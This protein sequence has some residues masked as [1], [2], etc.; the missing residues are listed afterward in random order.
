MPVCVSDTVSAVIWP[1]SSLVCC[2]LFKGR[3]KEHPDNINICLR[4][5]VVVVVVVVCMC[6]YLAVFSFCLFVRAY[7]IQRCV[8]LSNCL[9]LYVYNIGEHKREEVILLQ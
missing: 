8:Y 7:C 5:S 3:T 1:H 9:S 2:S 6:I 4:S